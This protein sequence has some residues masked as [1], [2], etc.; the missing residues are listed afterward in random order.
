MAPHSSAR[1]RNCPHSAQR[2]HN[3]TR[4]CSE[5]EAVDSALCWI[6]QSP[7]PSSN[8]RGKLDQENCRWMTASHREAQ[9]HSDCIPAPPLRRIGSAPRQTATNELLL[10]PAFK[11][12]A[13]SPRS[14]RSQPSTPREFPWRP[15]PGPRGLAALPWRQLGSWGSGAPA[16]R[17]LRTRRSLCVRPVP[18]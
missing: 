13:H 5:A 11:N 17:R 9:S 1:L 8:R 6:L 3:L 12:R 16:H 7:Y 18:R 4:C 14:G 2:R 10:P 15:R